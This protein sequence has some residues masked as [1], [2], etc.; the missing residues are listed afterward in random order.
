MKK[1]IAYILA[2]LA[3]AGVTGVGVYHHKD[4]IARILHLENKE[5]VKQE[6]NQGQYENQDQ[7]QNQGENQ[8]QNQDQDTEKPATPVRV[9]VIFYL[10]GNIYDAVVTD[11]GTEITLP[12]LEDTDT[13]YFRGWQIDGSSELYTDQ[14]V[15]TESVEFNPVYEEAPYNFVA[16]SFS[17]SVTN[18]YGYN[19]WTDGANA[20]LYSGSNHYVFN[21]TGNIWN[22]IDIGL[23]SFNVNNIWTDGTNTYYSDGTSHYVFDSENQKFIET[24]WT[25]LTEFSGTNILKDGTNIYY[26]AESGSY[27]LDIESKTWKS[28]TTQMITD[29]ANASTWTDGTNTYCAVAVEK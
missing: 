3:T 18:F 2:I 29:Y 19:T 24:E 12:V 26:L 13:H 10:D 6:V 22:Q 17:G 28:S 1:L 8:D 11:S 16:T 15:L 14:Y 7:D 5:E 27:E 4:D 25:G 21:R 20:Y 9:A 23:T